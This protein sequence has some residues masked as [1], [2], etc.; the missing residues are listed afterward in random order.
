MQLQGLKPTL[1]KQKL[2]NYVQMG[3]RQVSM[4]E[5]LRLLTAGL[6]KVSSGSPGSITLKSVSSPLNP[7]S[8]LKMGTYTKQSIL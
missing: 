5:F 4:P 8:G 6:L 2:P 3:T 7:T 1:S